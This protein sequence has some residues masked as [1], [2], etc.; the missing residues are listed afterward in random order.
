[1]NELID[2]LTGKGS[3]Y[4]YAIITGFFTILPETVFSMYKIFDNLA[5]WV[6]IAI[7]RLIVALIILICVNWM[8]KIEQN[9]RKSVTVAGDNYTVQIEYGNI[10][11]KTDGK[12]VI[13]FDECY[14]TKIGEAPSDI[15]P[16]SLCGQ[17]LQKYPIDDMQELIDKAKVKPARRKS[18]FQSLP[19]YE[20]GTIVPKG[21]FLLLAFAKLDKNGR[22]F[23][24]YKEYLLCLDLLW[25]QI[26]C[27][28]GTSD[29]YIPILGSL[30]TNID[31]NPTQQELLDIMIKSY[32]LSPYKITK[33]Y[34]LHIMCR[35]R[36]DFSLC[37]IF[38]VEKSCN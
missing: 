33:P 17:F 30:I 9:K 36:E 1:M 14:T 12:K 19:C 20:P 2:Y 25:Q 13:N 23:L 26:H 34:K 27:F 21:E 18:L 35:E 38:K 8:Y 3:T 5:V 37:N 7:N 32:M 4:A 22:A 16:K 11:E 29:V 24:S 28:Y 10:F 15:K 31:T 6:N